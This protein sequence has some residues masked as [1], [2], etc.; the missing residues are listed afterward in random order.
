MCFEILVPL[1]S[2]AY[3]AYSGEQQKDVA[4]KS[5]QNQSQLGAA[6]LLQQQDYNDSTMGNWATQNALAEKQLL[7]D[8]QIYG[9]DQSNLSGG[10]TNTT[11]SPSITSGTSTITGTEGNLDLIPGANKLLGNN[12]NV[13]S[14]S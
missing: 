14:W 6:S 7:Q 10:D 11:A 1:L 9:L 13:Y 3:N 2:F 12:Q 5:A 8:R 4:K